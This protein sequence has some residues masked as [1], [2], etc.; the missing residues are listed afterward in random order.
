ME[1]RDNFS[2]TAFEHSSLLIFID[3]ALEDEMAPFIPEGLRSGFIG[4]FH[5][6]TPKAPVLIAELGRVP[7]NNADRHFSSCMESGMWLVSQ[8]MSTK[9]NHG[10]IRAGV[11]VLSFAGP[12]S[13]E[14][15][16]TLLLLASVKLRLL[17]WYETDEIAS[18]T[19]NKLYWKVADEKLRVKWRD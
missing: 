8:P 4:V 1:D 13:V 5:E 19:R 14:A 17:Q 18:L 15:A 11:H 9:R 6:E 2:M 10:A 7:A 3:C 12:L 16:E